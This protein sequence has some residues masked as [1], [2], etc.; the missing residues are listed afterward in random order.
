[1]SNIV[2]FFKKGKKTSD[3]HKLGGILES[4]PTLLKTIKVMTKKETS[5]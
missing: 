4:A 2:Q 3:E 5:F 1:M